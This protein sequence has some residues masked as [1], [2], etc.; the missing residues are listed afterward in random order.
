M[1]LPDRPVADSIKDRSA[2]CHDLL[3]RRVLRAEQDSGRSEL[4]FDI[5]DQFTNGM[6]NV[7]GGFLAAMLDSTLGAAIATVLVEGERPPTI[8]MKINFMRPA[9]VGMIAG[10]A[11]VVQRGRSLAFVEGELRNA[12]GELLATGTSTNLIIRP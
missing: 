3:G 7:Q 2:P 10:T 11:R 9:K 6:G 5:S 12:S 1:S 4:S 8:E